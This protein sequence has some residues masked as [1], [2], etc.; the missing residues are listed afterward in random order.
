LAFDLMESLA[1]KLELSDPQLA[2]KIAGTVLTLG[3]DQANADAAFSVLVK[4]VDLQVPGLAVLDL[5]QA[6]LGR[7]ETR[8]FGARALRMIARTKAFIDQDCPDQLLEAVARMIPESGSDID[9]LFELA[10]SLAER[11]QP[12]L[13]VEILTRLARTA[14]VD[15]L[16]SFVSA[17]L[18][19]AQCA[20]L[21]PVLD[22]IAGFLRKYD[23]VPATVPFVG[24]PEGVHR[25]RGTCG[26]PE[27]AEDLSL[28]AFGVSVQLHFESGKSGHCDGR[29]WRL[30]GVSS[31]SKM[32]E[33][34]T[35]IVPPLL[36][37]AGSSGKHFPVVM[38]LLARFSDTDPIT[39]AEIMEENLALVSI[40]VASL[41]KKTWVE[42]AKIASASPA[43]AELALRSWET[44]PFLVGFLYLLEHCL[45][46]TRDPARVRP[47]LDR[48]LARSSASTG[49]KQAEISRL[50]TA[51]MDE[52]LYNSG[53]W[54]NRE[55]GG[56]ALLIYHPISPSS[57][58]SGDARC[59]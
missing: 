8:R 35:Q 36:K 49:A 41:G 55:I 22:V 42:F 57:R 11:I 15:R 38:R 53:L 32:W 23:L 40:I 51:I 6:Q 1:R 34:M 47:I 52:H 37:L 28:A 29:L 17:W 56:G 54:A 19:H 48:Y 39:F 5:C 27:R 20:D 7:S 24:F 58:D 3:S 31:S 26:V 30:F 50:C 14:L 2:A 25:P 59:E 18:A 10:T 13:T 44:G 16:W 12:Q 21:S 43:F 46:D 4:L 9:I 33:N 45:E